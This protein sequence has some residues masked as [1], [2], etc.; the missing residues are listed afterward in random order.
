MSKS[1]NLTIFIDTPLDIAMARR[2]LRDFKEFS[3]E[4]IRKDLDV[5]LSRGRLGYLEALNSIKLNSDFIIEGS[6]SVE[7]IVKQVY[8]VIISKNNL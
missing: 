6:L 8:E 3:F 2:I 4:N 7:A 5:Y 1:I